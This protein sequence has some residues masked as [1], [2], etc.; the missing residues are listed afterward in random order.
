MY[1]QGNNC[2]QPNEYVLCGQMDPEEVL[3]VFTLLAYHLLPKLLLSA[4]EDLP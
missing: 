1:S 2:R 4:A 3:Q